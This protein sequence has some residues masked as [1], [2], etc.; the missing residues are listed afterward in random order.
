MQYGRLA[1]CLLRVGCTQHAIVPHLR[2][3]AGISCCPSSGHATVQ[4][5]TVPSAQLRARVQGVLAGV[6]LRVRQVF[7]RFRAP[8]AADEADARFAHFRR[9]VWPR[10]QEAGTSGA[11]LHEAMYAI[12]VYLDRAQLGPQPSC[13]LEVDGRF[14]RDLV[15]EPYV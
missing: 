5:A 1:V 11:S 15:Q 7:E 8:R 13:N 4:P 9:L 12:C 2:A 6:L 10:M 14:L 3:L